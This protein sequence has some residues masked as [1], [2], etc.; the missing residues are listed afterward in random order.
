[1]ASS[2]Q[3]PSYEEVWEADSKENHPLD[4]HGLG[5]I[6][7]EDLRGISTDDAISDVDVLCHMC[8]N[9]VRVNISFKVSAESL[10]LALMKPKHRQDNSNN[11]NNSSISDDAASDVEPSLS[12]KEME[13]LA[14][15]DDVIVHDLCKTEDDTQGLI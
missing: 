7:L 4:H 14:I 8:K 9:G 12:T 2:S 5:K 1:M 10:A 15:L 13:A 11:N 6:S 3:P